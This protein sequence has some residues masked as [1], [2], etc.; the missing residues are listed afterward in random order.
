MDATDRLTR[1][2]QQGVGIAFGVSTQIVFLITVWY[3]FWFLRDGAVSQRHDHWIIRDC[4]L[5]T[6]FAVAHSVMLVPA[7][8]RYLSRWIPASFYDSVFCVVTCLS[9]LLLSSH[10]GPV[11]SHYGNSRAGL[12]R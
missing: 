2:T 5:A 11:R 10:G 4:A 1:W 3:L 8:R 9:L 12:I 7:S 6:F